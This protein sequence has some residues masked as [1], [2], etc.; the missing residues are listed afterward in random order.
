MFLAAEKFQPMALLSELTWSTS[1]AAMS[2]SLTSVSPLYWLFVDEKAFSIS[3]TLAASW[4]TWPRTSPRLSASVSAPP[5]SRLRSLVW[6]LIR[7]D[8]PASMDAD[9]ARLIGGPE[10]LRHISGGPGDAADCGDIRQ[11]ADPVRHLF[12][13]REGLRGAK[14][15]R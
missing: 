2:T 15:M 7:V 6:S 8:P 9:S 5:T 12:Q 1:W 10:L 11:L 3:C 4:L 13:V 14:V